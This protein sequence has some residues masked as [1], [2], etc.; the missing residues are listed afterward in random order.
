[1]MKNW[2]QIVV[3]VRRNYTTNIYPDIISPKNLE[4]G[5]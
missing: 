3:A 1:M 2:M 4:E 5:D